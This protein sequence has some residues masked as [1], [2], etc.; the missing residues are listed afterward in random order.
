M[1]DYDS[2]QPSSYIQSFKLPCGNF[3]F[4]D[5]PDKFDFQKVDINGEKGYLLEVDLNYPTE[6]HDVH[7][8]LPLAPEH[9]TVTPQM[10]SEYN[11]GDQSFR[12]QTCLFSNLRDKSRYVLHIRISNYTRISA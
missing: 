3:R 4:I 8:D 10:L 1:S 7:S 5:E 11:R 6:L 2:S 12:G 9:I